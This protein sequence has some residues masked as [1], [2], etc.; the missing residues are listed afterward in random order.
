LTVIRELGPGDDDL[1]AAASHLFD[2]P[3]HPEA[4]SDFLADGR[5]HLLVAHEGSRPVG[6]VSGVGVTHLD[7]G[8]E[9]FLHELAVDE[10]YRRQVWTF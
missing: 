6:F 2:G 5:H 4:T 9:M 8:T 7:K 3:S 10:P 1:V